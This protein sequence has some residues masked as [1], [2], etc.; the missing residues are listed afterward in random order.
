M[1]KQW[2]LTAMMAVGLTITMVACAPAPLGDGSIVAGNGTGDGVTR[3]VDDEADIVCWVYD[4]YK[5]G[6]IDCMPISE[7]G[8]QR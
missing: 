1:T 4:G 7:T 8:L 6:G 2:F 5:A 3:L